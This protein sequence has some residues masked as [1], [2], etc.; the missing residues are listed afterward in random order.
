[1]RSEVLTAM[2]LTILHFCDVTLLKPEKKSHYDSTK[3]REILDQRHSV[4]S[5][6]SLSKSSVLKKC[7][8]LL[9][10]PLKSNRSY[11]PYIRPSPCV[12]KCDSHRMN[13]CEI[14]NLV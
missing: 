6:K 14:Y 1:M 5:Q 4:T 11:W 10:G 2:L 8:R 3:R 12:E 9:S 13:S 7:Q